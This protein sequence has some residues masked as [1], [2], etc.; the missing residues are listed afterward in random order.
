MSRLLKSLNNAQ[1]E[2]QQDATRP[3]Q[4]ESEDAES[5]DREPGYFWTSALLLALV[6]GLIV[7]GYVLLSGSISGLL[8]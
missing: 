2:R 7:G 5:A 6:C 1:R 3:R 4:V 8:Q